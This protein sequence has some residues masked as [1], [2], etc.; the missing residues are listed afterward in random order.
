MPDDDPSRWTPARRRQS[1]AH[2]PADESHDGSD[3]GPYPSAAERRFDPR[4]TRASRARERRLGSNGSGGGGFG[5]L[6]RFLAL[7]RRARRAGDRRRPH[8]PPAA[9]RERGRRLGRRQPDG[10]RSAVRRR[11][12]P[13]GP[14]QRP[15][16]PPSDRRRPRSSSSWRPATRRPPS[17]TGS[18][19]RAFL[20]NPRAFVFLA[21]TQHLDDRLEAGT[22]ILRRN[23]TPR[24]ARQRAARGHSENDHDHVPRRA[25]GSNRSRRSSRR[26]RSQARWSAGF[27]DI[28]TH[29]PDVASGRLP[30]AATCRQGAS[31]EGFLWPA[32][33]GCRRTSRPKQLIR[34]LLDNSRS[35]SGGGADERPEGARPDVLPGR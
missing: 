7:R 15:D 19:R 20:R 2:R 17:R 29:P 24:A 35:R 5:G 21:T 31:L 1:Q 22:Y 27:Y 3:Q 6:L 11:P 30:V 23:M 10:A 9:R 16:D 25:C 4:D 13:R 34:M 8:R 14:R 26:C 12:R 32:T 18:R 28:A 33:Y